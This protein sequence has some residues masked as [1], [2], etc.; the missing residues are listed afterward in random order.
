MQ[1]LFIYGKGVNHH[2]IKSLKGDPKG[3]TG[4]MK[5]KNRKQIQ[6]CRVSHEKIHKGQYEGLNLKDQ[7]K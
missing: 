4:V 6:V 3:L 7:H 2:H 1:N 5:A